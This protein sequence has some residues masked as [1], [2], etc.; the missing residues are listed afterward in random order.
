M[1]NNIS[2][3]KPIYIYFFNIILTGILT[4]IFHKS[5]ISS[6]LIASLISMLIE[7]YKKNS[8]MGDGLEAMLSTFLMLA[9]VTGISTFIFWVVSFAIVFICSLI[10]IIISYTVTILIV[11]FV[12]FIIFC[13]FIGKK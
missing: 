1:K 10:G 8:S 7:K 9:V 3:L 4:I 2:K 13:L 11:S 5:I 12:L 6:I